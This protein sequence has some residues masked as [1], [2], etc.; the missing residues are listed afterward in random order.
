MNKNSDSH[1]VILVVL[2]EG[3]VAMLIK[4]SISG[5]F[6]ECSFGAGGTR[7]DDVPSNN[8][9]KKRVLEVRASESK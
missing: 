9:A 8:W 1:E 7:L 2:T 6:I 3:E 5:K 4:E